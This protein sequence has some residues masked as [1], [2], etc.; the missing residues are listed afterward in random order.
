MWIY[1]YLMEV[2][3]LKHIPFNSLAHDVNASGRAYV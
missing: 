1:T 3:L 2:I